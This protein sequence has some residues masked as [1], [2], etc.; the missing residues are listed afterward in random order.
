MTDR[1][2]PKPWFRVFEENELIRRIQQD[3]S[4]SFYGQ[5][6]GKFNDFSKW[7]LRNFEQNQS[8]MRKEIKEIDS[9]NLSAL[10]I[11]FG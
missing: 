1:V 10:S 2:T 4:A 6:F 11:L 3:G 7:K 9:F 5:F 8:N